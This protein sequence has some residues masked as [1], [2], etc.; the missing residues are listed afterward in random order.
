MQGA[1]NGDRA[2]AAI[3]SFREPGLRSDSIT[4]AIALRLQR[5]A[6]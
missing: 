1:R 5:S 2:A 4:S 3:H 6:A